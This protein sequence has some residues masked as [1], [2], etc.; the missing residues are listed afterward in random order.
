MNRPSTLAEVVRR[1][2]AE[3]QPLEI[4]LPGFLDT[5]Y[6]RPADRQTM[7]DPA[8]ELTGDAIVDASMGAIGEHLARRWGL[9]IPV[10]T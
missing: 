9:R 2:K 6:T 3:T 7:I 5:F 4:S 8:P 10:W 1:L